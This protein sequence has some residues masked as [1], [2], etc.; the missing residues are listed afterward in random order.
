ME[1]EQRKIELDDIVRIDWL[2]DGH[3]AFWTRDGYMACSCGWSDNDPNYNQSTQMIHDSILKRLIKG[4]W[5]V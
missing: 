4:G 2:P 1:T 3:C 5:E